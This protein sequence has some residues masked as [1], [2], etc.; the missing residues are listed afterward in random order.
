MHAAKTS[1]LTVMKVVSTAGS[2]TVP[3]GA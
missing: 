1:A 3:K 2:G